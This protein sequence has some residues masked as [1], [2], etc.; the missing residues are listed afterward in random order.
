MSYAYVYA[1][2]SGTV[3]QRD[4]AGHCPCYDSGECGSDMQPIDIA[5]SGTAPYYI[6]LYVNYSTVKSIYIATYTSGSWECCDSSPV[7]N[8][9]KRAIRVNLYSGWNRSGYIGYVL[10]GHVD[11]SGQYLPNVDANGNISQKW[12]GRLGK[13]VTDET[14]PNCSDGDPDTPCCYSGAHVHMECG[15]PGVYYDTRTSMTQGSS[16]VFEFWFG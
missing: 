14:D 12:V 5:P 7:S 2:F 10:F 6:N 8:N 13:V 3:T 4:A 11:L 1:P 16:P 9:L 15:N